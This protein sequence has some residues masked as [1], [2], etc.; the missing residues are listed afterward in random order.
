MNPTRLLLLSTSAMLTLLLLIEWNEFSAEQS[1]SNAADR[2]AIS[3][4]PSSTASLN[5]T[6]TGTDSLE[7]NPADDSDDIPTAIQPSTDTP[8]I[9]TVGRSLIDLTTDSLDLTIDLRGG[10]IVRASLPKFLEQLDN[11][12]EPF[13]LLEDNTTRTY[14]AQSGLIGPD[15]I[16]GASG[17]ADYRYVATNIDP[18][19]NSTEVTLNWTGSSDLDVQKIFT[20]YEHCVRLL[21]TF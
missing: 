11:P 4:Q 8:T 9:R 13:L 17:R 5:S 20:A 16:D 19:N 10:D 14:V 2:F 12:D 3:D 7:P 1:V 21:D 6:I 15:G 18:E